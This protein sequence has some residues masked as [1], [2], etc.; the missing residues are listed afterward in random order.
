MTLYCS[1]QYWINY[2]C[3][4]RQ[5]S[6]FSVVCLSV[7]LSVR[8][9][10]TERK[11]LTLMKIRAEKDCSRKVLINLWK[12]MARISVMDNPVVNDDVT[13]KSLIGKR[14]TARRI[15]LLLTG[16]DTFSFWRDV[17]EVCALATAVGW[18]QRPYGSCYLCSLQCDRVTK[19]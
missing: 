8:L 3:H 5:S 16:I 6:V 18:C 10:T 15:Y 13:S 4:F 2:F 11:K 19:K 12:I 9:W 1:D 17:A 7:S 14:F